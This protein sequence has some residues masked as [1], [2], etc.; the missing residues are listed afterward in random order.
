MITRHIA[1]GLIWVLSAAGLWTVTAFGR[2]QSLTPQDITQAIEWGQ[3][4]RPEGYP[5]RS[6]FPG[7]KTPP[8]AVYTPYLRVA[9][10]ARAAREEGRT[11][12][13]G[14]VT[15]EMTAPLIYFAIGEVGENP[16]PAAPLPVDAPLA[17]RLTT[18]HSHPGSSRRREIS[19]VW[20][21]RDVAAFLRY[22]LRPKWSYMFAAF[23]PEDVK[24]DTRVELYRE[25]R[26]GS[27]R[28]VLAT[29]GLV[30]EADVASWR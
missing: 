18:E 22:G 16:L 21:R 5:L 1:H 29:P 14:D 24:P 2:S 7:N 23:R 27:H 25:F 15:A 8:G 30:T 3:S 26:E 20:T 17:M 13:T 11:F 28:E 19:P 10:A 4:G 12:T 6:A 9:L